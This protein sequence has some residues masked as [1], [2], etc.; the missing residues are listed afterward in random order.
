MITTIHPAFGYTILKQRVPANTILN[1]PPAVD[2]IY[3]VTDVSKFGQTTD[4]FIWLYISGQT[5][6]TNIY[7]GEV[8]F[9]N[10]GHCNIVTPEKIGTF[11]HEIIEDS[12]IFCM[13]GGVNVK[14]LPLPALQYFN[15]PVGSKTELSP[16]TKLFLAD[17]SITIDAQT[18]IG[19]K[20]IKIG[21]TAK[22]VTANTQCYGYVFP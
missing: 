8:Q 16:N 20:Q 19:P 9:R 7:T 12:V 1:E 18:F 21:D 6:V 22:E 5:K 10:P 2:G 4:G 11:R 17:G 3:T 15:L 13:S 14:K